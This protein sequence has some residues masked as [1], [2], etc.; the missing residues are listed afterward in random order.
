MIFRR[1]VFSSICAGVWL[2]CMFVGPMHTVSAE[3]RRCHGPL[4]TEVTDI[5]ALTCG[6]NGSNQSS[7]EE[8][9]LLTV[10]LS[11]QPNIHRSL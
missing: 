9:V 5:C 1:Y 11:F 7:L 2:I 8:Q 4:R 10:E 3:V 6:C